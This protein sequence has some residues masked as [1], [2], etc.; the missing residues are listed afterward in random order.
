VNSA[1]GV[2]PPSDREIRRFLTQQIRVPSLFWT[3]SE[4]Q[5]SRAQ[6]PG[7]FLALSRPSVDRLVRDFRIFGPVWN[8]S[9]LQS[10]QSALLSFRIEPDREHILCG[11][12]IPTYRQIPFR[13][14]RNV[15]RRASSSSEVVRP[16]IVRFRVGSS[17]LSNLSFS[18]PGRRDA[19]KISGC[20][21]LA[22]LS[23]DLKQEAAVLALLF[24][25]EAD[26]ISPRLGPR[27]TQG[28]HIRPSI[29]RDLRFGAV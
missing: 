14:Y 12:D 21:V 11:S 19:E 5:C 4:E 2:I 17:A 10:I 23:T 27:G 20:E 6:T 9:P 26:V 28:D 15:I 1:S 13:R 25:H 24:N 8:Q 29:P 7:H 18:S 22:S 16:H 3:P